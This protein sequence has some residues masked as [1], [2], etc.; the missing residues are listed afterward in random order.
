MLSTKVKHNPTLETVLADREAK[1]EK[2]KLLATKY[3]APVIGI[4]VNIPGPEKKTPWAFKL[5]RAAVDAVEKMLDEKGI[6][7]CSIEMKA[8]Y[9]F[10]TL[11]V[12]HKE[13]PTLKRYLVEIEESCEIGR[14]FDLDVYMADGIPLSRAEGHERKCYLCDEPAHA[15]AR[16]RAHSFKDLEQYLISKAD[17]L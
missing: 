17:V 8:H 2:V 9:E 6:V 4:R 1:A 3:H 16:S 11:V 14:I 12:A 10:L 15:C 5:Y 13:A 7:Y